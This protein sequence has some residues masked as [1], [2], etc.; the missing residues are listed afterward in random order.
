LSSLLEVRQRL[1]SHRGVIVASLFIAQCVRTRRLVGPRGGNREA[2]C[3]RRQRC[4]ADIGRAGILRIHRPEAFARSISEC[5]RSNGEAARGWG[6]RKLCP[7]LLRLGTLDRSAKQAGLQTTSDSRNC[8]CGTRSQAPWSSREGWSMVYQPV[9][10]AGSFSV[11]SN[12]N[13][14][15]LT[16]SIRADVAASDKILQIEEIRL[17]DGRQ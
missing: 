17:F 5:S 7:A 15:L 8:R 12:L 13:T 4:R 14:Q 10:Q 9:W 6:Q 1:E 16:G 3:G 11:R 2:D